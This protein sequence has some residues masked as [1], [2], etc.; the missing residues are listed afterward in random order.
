LIWPTSQH[1]TLYKFTAHAV[2]HNDSHELTRPALLI[3]EYGVSLS[4][5]QLLQFALLVTKLSYTVEALSSPGGRSKG[6][7]KS[8]RLRKS[9]F[10]LDSGATFK[11]RKR[12][13]L[14]EGVSRD[15]DPASAM[16]GLHMGFSSSSPLAARLLFF[17]LSYPGW[18]F[19]L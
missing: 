16:H 13:G 10:R 6:L 4:R 12:Y 15:G 1:P 5:S 2:C 8:N 17:F 3:P 11:R 18:L 14:G 9:S 7:Q 19:A